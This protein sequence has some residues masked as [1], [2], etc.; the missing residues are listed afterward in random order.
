MQEKSHTCEE[1]EAHLIFIDE[2]S[3]KTKK[4]L[5]VPS[6]YIGVPNIMIR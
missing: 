2:L 6:F 1:A 4:A 3:N 5:E